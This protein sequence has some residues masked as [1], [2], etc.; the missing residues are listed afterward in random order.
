MEITHFAFI[1]SH[2]NTF[3]KILNVLLMAYDS[4]LTL[5]HRSYITLNSAVTVF[6][7]GG[8]QATGAASSAGALQSLS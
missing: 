2:Y 1:I 3:R 7:D 5:N 8:R 6:Q 4:G